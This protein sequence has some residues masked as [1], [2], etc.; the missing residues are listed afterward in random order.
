MQRTLVFVGA[1][2]KSLSSLFSSNDESMDPV[3][4][5]TESEFDGEKSPLQQT[6]FPSIMRLLMLQLPAV[7]NSSLLRILL[8]AVGCC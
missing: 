6:D 8:S 2:M 5:L 7:R 3:M 1:R 4:L